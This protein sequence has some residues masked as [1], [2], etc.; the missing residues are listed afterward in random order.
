[1]W[2]PGK[3]TTHPMV[4]VRVEVDDSSYA[5]RNLVALRHTQSRNMLAL[6]NSGAQMG[7]NLQGRAPRACSTRAPA[8]RTRT[9]SIQRVKFKEWLVRKLQP[10]GRAITSTRPQELPST[11]SPA[12]SPASDMAAQE[13]GA[14][15]IAGHPFSEQQKT[16]P[17]NVLV[18]TPRA[19]GSTINKE[20]RR[21]LHL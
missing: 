18:K 12:P 21:V 5:S 7:K 17:E 4:K 14:K 6:A 19:G 13:T 8:L 3:V 9:L 15:E 2:I 11:P 1:M 16:E 10:G 20:D